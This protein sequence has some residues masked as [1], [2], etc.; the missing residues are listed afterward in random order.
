MYGPFDFVS[1]T[2]LASL[3]TKA[4]V[5]NDPAV[6]ASWAPHATDGYYVGP[7]SNHYRCLRFYIPTTRCF[8]FVDTWRLYPSH[9]QVPVMSE[10]DE[11]LLAANAFLQRLGGLVPTSAQDKIKHLEAIQRLTAI[12]PG[13]PDIPSPQTM[14]HLRGWQLSHSEGGDYSTTESGDN[15]QHH[16]GAQHSTSTP[17]VFTNASPGP[18]TP[19]KS[20][21]MMMTMMTQSS[22]ATAAQFLQPFLFTWWNINL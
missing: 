1:K 5:Y 10:N 13:Q 17:L 14:P 21:L 19:S 22:T 3:G 2:P 8:R 12:M 9:R 16:C 7:A 20:Y 15:V 6:R 11:R 18:P 4:L